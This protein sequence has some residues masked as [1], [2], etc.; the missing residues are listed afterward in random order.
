[1][2]EVAGETHEIGFKVQEYR[3]PE[4]KL[5]IQPEPHALRA[6]RPDQRPDQASYYF[7]APVAGRS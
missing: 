6:G 3:K 5:E 1:M 4:F 2:A 7:G